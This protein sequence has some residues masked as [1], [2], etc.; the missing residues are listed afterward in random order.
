MMVNM[1]WFYAQDF[2]EEEEEEEE[3]GRHK[4]KKRKGALGFIIDEAGE[5]IYDNNQL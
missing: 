2:D 1:L 4:K 5:L 3:E